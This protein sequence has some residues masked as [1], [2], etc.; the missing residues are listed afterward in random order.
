MILINSILLSTILLNFKIQKGKYTMALNML[1]EFVQNEEFQLLTEATIL[2][3]SVTQFLNPII[4]NLEQGVQSGKDP[5]KGK[6]SRQWV[7]KVLGVLGFM[8][9]NVNDAY[10]L[11]GIDDNKEKLYTF[12]RV[13]G[14]TGASS[15]KDRNNAARAEKYI[16]W[17]SQKSLKSAVEKLDQELSVF[18]QVGASDRNTQKKKEDL[19]NRA[20]K[21]SLDLDKLMMKIKHD[22]TTAKQPGI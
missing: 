22:A 19:V 17:W 2:L 16:D 20:K 12:L 7:A 21:I 5:F 3:E 18:S 8:S 6:L 14:D 15:Q 10:S 9:K 13:L 1:K 4:R 11:D